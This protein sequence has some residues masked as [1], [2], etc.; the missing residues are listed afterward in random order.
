MR[1]FLKLAKNEFSAALK[2]RVH[3]WRM[4]RFNSK[5]GNTILSPNVSLSAVVGHTVTVLS[6]THVD[7]NCRLQSYSWIGLNCKV[8]KAD[9]G[10]Y[11]GIA[12]N[13]SI[14]PGEHDLGSINNS[15][16]FEADLYEKLTKRPC[17]I[18]PDVWI[19]VDSIVR[20]GVT[21][22]VGAIVG[23]NSFVNKDVPPY[24]VVA[25]TPARL[26]RFRFN[27]AQVELLEKS[28]WWE[29]DFVDAK[30]ALDEL[31]VEVAR[32]ASSGAGQ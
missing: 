14:G 12:D 24:A 2:A 22:G 18:G 9:I 11:A 29:L 17:V 19:G 32:Y 30:K 31:H 1:S 8:T 20:R 7:S 10:R 4:I 6:G 21:I 28:K 15:A 3:H 5:T 25:G 26:V 27:A 23:A 16:L 13:V